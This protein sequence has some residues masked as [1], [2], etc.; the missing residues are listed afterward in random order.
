LK[1]AKD[2][3]NQ[4]SAK[5][6]KDILWKMSYRASYNKEM[7]KRLP[8]AVALI[9][10]AFSCHQTIQDKTTPDAKIDESN[11]VK[12]S[13]LHGTW[14]RRIK[15]ALTL[16]EIKDTSDVH[17]YEFADM[18]AGKGRTNANPWYYISKGRIGYW[19]SKTIWIGTDKFRFDYKLKGD[20]LIEFDKMGDQGIFIKLHTDQEK[21]F[22][23]FNQTR[24]QGKITYLNKVDSSE[25]FGLD[26]IYKEFSF[27]SIA[28]SASG[29]KSFSELAA[30]GDSIIKP[31][32][33]DSLTLYK[34]DSGLYF[35]LSF[36]H[37]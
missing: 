24:L 18:S 9:T 25:L 33:A 30:I 16:I 34:K 12:Y 10:I 31:A 23:K 2:Y 5:T 37:Q 21:A 19:D 3:E 26:N 32:G 17:Y 15:G 13:G 4:N 1:T 8:A 7:T 29:N 28:G 27:T 11:K 14:V 35:R 22:I 36:V 6:T 20:S